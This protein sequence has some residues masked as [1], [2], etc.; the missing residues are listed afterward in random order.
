M[1]SEAPPLPES[2]SGTVQSMLSQLKQLQKT[3]TNLAAKISVFKNLQSSTVTP[4]SSETLA[5]MRENK[6]AHA[7]S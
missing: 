2:F 1:L 7:E 4:N 6:S 3:V 5:A